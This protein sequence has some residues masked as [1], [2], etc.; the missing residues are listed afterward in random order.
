MIFALIF[1]HACDI[2]TVMINLGGFCGSL[3][4]SGGS[5]GGTAFP[6]ANFGVYDFASPN[7][8]FSFTGCVK[9]TQ[10]I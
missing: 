8:L 2:C 6:A 10:T 4:C 7:V 9:D 1:T 3:L 5:V